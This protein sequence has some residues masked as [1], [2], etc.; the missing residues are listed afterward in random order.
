MSIVKEYIEIAVQIN[1][2]CN[3]PKI[4][5]IYLPEQHETPDV[6][7]EF[8]LIFLRGGV[9]APFYASLPG[10]LETLWHKFPV[11][12]K[13][14]LDLLDLIRLFADTNLANKAIALGAF[15]AMS[16]FVMKRAGLLPLN[17]Q[18]GAN[19]GSARPRA[20]ER[21]GMVGYFC[22]LIDKLV[23]RGVE[24]LVLEKQPERVE[25]RPGVLMSENPADLEPCRVILC[26]AATLIND[27]IDEILAHCK[28]AENFS[29]IGPSGSGL[30]DVLFERG[31]DAVGGVYF[32]DKNQLSARLR[33]RESWG[34][35]GQKYQLTPDSYPGYEALLSRINKAPFP[36][37]NIES[38]N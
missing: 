16:Q 1:L 31:V 4:A 24:I 23:D 33:D 32:P 7:D 12:Q 8:G 13:I 26:T 21:I 29:L 17:N 25:L 6:R 2:H 11:D 38:E 36:N 10:T 18:T 30:P 27:S 3:L 35:A 20:G 22:P 9:V 19:M 34:E 15:N 37:S 28:H 14:E 5:R